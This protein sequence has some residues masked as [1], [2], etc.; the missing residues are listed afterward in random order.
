MK[1]I[2]KGKF[3][4]K[5]IDAL[6]K[7]LLIGISVLAC[8]W[9]V[10]GAHAAQSSQITGIKAE[11]QDD[12]SYAIDFILSQK[13]SPENVTVEFERNFIQVS[14]KGV[15]AYPA[16]TENIQQAV[17]DK[18]FTYQYQP[19][20]ARARVLLKAAAS[21]IKNK[22]SWEI[23]GNGLR[24]LVKG[25]SG[26]AHSI[27]DAL[28]SKSASSASTE[29]E[30]TLISA[31]TDEER[32]VQEILAENKPGAKSTAASSATTGGSI[33]TKEATKTDKGTAATKSSESTSGNSEEQALFSSKSSGSST[34]TKGTENAATR[35]IASLLLVIG[36]IGAGAV[37]YRRFTG[38]KGLA[39]QRQPKVI[40]VIASQSMG[41]KRSVA[42]IKVLDQYMVVGMAGDGMNLLANL[43][44]DVKI[45]RHIDQMGA[46]DSFAD[47]FEGALSGVT[48]KTDSAGPAVTHKSGIDMGIRSAIKKRIEGFK[49]L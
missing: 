12:G 4:E 6:S 23:N 2:R 42:L 44:S 35:T 46:G 37:A 14:L 49:P 32:I 33:S 11:A 22:A 28:K 8:L 18:V 47:A 27:T 43:G 34:G 7:V 39:F 38:G 9:M 10:S 19:D 17:L 31:N 15:S 1:F 48:P 16:R 21:T 3:R 30:P 45:E 41:P 20:L 25:V 26:V 29:I 40:E 24:I 36:L 13:L 5:F